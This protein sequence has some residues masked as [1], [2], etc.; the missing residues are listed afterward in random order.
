MYDIKFRYA[1]RMGYLATYTDGVQD[2][3]VI[4]KVLQYRIGTKVEKL[5]GFYVD[6]GPWID[7]LTEDE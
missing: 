1:K 4:A 6:Y 7:V 2:R 5:T 3:A